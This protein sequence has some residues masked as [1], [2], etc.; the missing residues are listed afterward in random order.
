MA[1]TSYDAMATWKHSEVP[2]PT[3]CPRYNTREQ[4]RVAM[5]SKSKAYFLIDGPTTGTF[6]TPSSDG[7]LTFEEP[8]VVSTKAG[9]YSTIAVRPGSPD[10]IYVGRRIRRTTPNCSPGKP[11]NFRAAGYDAAVSVSTDGGATF[12]EPIQLN[13]PAEP[14]GNAE[15]IENV[16]VAVGPG[17]TVYALFVSRQPPPPDCTGPGQTAGRNQIRNAGKG[18]LYLARSLDN[19][20][21]WEPGDRRLVADLTNQPTGPNDTANFAEYNGYY[22]DLA[23]DQK[24]GA[25]YVVWSDERNG[26]ADTFLSRSFDGGQGWSP[27]GRVSTDAPGNRDRQDRNS[28]A[29]APNG[30]VDL[31]YQ[32][33]V[34]LD[35]CPKPVPQPRDNIP[36]Y[37]TNIFLRTSTDQAATFGEAFKLNSSPSTTGFSAGP[38]TEA[39]ATTSGRPWPRSTSW[40]TWCGTT[41][42]SAPTTTTTATSPVP[43]PSSTPSSSSCLRPTSSW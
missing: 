33:A 21:T 5:G 13:D 2:F 39:T 35:A 29:V 34:R 11:A 9:E 37:D 19:G 40:R 31:V 38:G 24:S 12:A 23:V 42:G 41:P 28:I 6:L 26:D 3:S 25:V 15:S 32:E 30:R 36:C 27:P 1:H 16:E 20:K 4:F 43:A 7:G 14:L 18:K 10:Q 17:Q 22:S 8:V